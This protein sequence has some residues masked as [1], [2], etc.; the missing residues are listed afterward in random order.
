MRLYIHNEETWSYSR[1]A[2]CQI[3]GNPARFLP[4]AACSE[5]EGIAVRT[6]L[7]NARAL[8]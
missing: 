4:L 1:H 6:C 7:Y 5:S 8:A 2:I 3:G